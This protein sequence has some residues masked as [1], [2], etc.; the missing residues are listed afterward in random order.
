MAGRL[1]IDFGTSNTVVTVWNE[2][3]N[4]SSS[5]LVRD[6]SRVQDAGGQKINVIPSL[7]HYGADFKHLIGNQVLRQNRTAGASGDSHRCRCDSGSANVAYLENA[8]G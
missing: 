4:D 5:L 6:Y 7:I 2:S 3:Q 1:G 8:G